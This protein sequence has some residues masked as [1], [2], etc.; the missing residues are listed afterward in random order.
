MKGIL[1]STLTLLLVGCAS[2]YSQ[3]YQS[4]P[5]ATPERI[6]AYRAAPPPKVPLLV[7]T[8]DSP[9]TVGDYYE[10]QGYVLIGSSS[11]TSGRGESEQAALAQGAKVGADLVVI[12]NPTYAGSTQGV[13]PLTLPTSQ[14]TYTSGTATAYGSG[15]SVT[16]YGSGTST[17][18]GST[19]SYI[20][21]TINRYSYGA[22]Y[23]IKHHF[24]L[25][26]LIRPLTDA[27][28]QQY[29][30][31]AG[32]YVRAVVDGT[33]AFT[34]DVLPG[35]ILMKIDGQPIGAAA[36]FSETIERFRGRK[37]EIQIK[38]GSVDVLKV[39]QLAN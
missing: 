37:V 12:I 19:T 14:T 15:G 11:F 3:F 21:Y 20:P 35:D 5:N 25:G 1:T 30:T 39:I 28:R 9:Q 38:R 17:T 7:K 34:S 13:M 10:R 4:T 26:T 29:Q 24:V 16:A 31:N 8:S 27:E 18:Y 22:G 33:P 6:A 23:F 36:D 32:I 2:G